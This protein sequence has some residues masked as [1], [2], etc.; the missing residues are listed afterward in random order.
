MKMASSVEAY[1]DS[2]REWA[3]SLELLRAIFGSVALD[4]T[5]KWGM[6]TYTLNNKNVAGFNAFKSYVGIWFFQ[7]VFLEDPAKKLI[8]AQEGTTRGQR[9]WRFKNAEEIKQNRKL[10][11]NYLEEAIQNQKD[12]KVI[13]A[14]KNKPLIIPPE[15]QSALQDKPE[16]KEGFDSLTRSRQRE[17]CVYISQA[18]REETRLIRL[19]K[20]AP[21]IIRGRG[22][23]DKHKK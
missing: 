7:G 1:I 6:P 14:Q 18:K 17:Y 8:N 15:L 22:L 16:L 9:Q 3:D 5:I 2:K 21:M 11:L 13:K 12:G 23:N 10:I 4:E 19:E 20:I